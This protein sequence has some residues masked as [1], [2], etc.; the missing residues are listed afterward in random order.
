RRAGIG[1]VQQH[2]SLAPNL[3]AA[4]NIMLGERGLYR[5][6]L[7]EA[8]LD[9]VASASG[10][11]LASTRSVADLSVVE[12]QRLEIL[13]ALARGARLLILDEPTALLTPSD[14][15]DLLQ[16][17]RAFA[18]RGGSVVFVTHKLREALA[19]ADDLTVLRRGRVAFA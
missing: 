8:L 19:I 15:R 6:R 3:S 5:P 9:R 4:E 13:K 7:A 17:I 18:D 1:M 14:T 16:W 12:Q 10:L 2:L 11:V